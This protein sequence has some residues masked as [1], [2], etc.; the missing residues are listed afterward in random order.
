MGF[1]TGDTYCLAE[2]SN[3]R[4]VECRSRI[5]SQRAALNG[6]QWF[7][8][9]AATKGSLIHRLIGGVFF[10]FMFVGMFGGAFAGY[11]VSEHFASKHPHLWEVTLLEVGMFGALAG[12]LAFRLWVLDMAF[13][14]YLARGGHVGPDHPR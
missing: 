10:A 13:R 9:L 8:F 2:P 3:R 11:F 1:R 5:S 12:S 6:W 4:T 14:R 7:A